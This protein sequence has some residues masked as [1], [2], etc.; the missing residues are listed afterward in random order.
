[1]KTSQPIEIAAKLNL[2]AS[3]SHQT[4]EEAQQAILQ[5]FL[6]TTGQVRIDHWLEKEIAEIDKLAAQRQHASR[7]QTKARSFDQYVTDADHLRAR[8]MSIRLD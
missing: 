6:E 1:M 4:A 5:E 3:L 7:K 8:G 2:Y